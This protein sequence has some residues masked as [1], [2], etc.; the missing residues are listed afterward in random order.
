M[1]LCL[2]KGPIVIECLELLFTAEQ[3]KCHISLCADLYVNS[4][5]VL[6]LLLCY[7]TLPKQMTNF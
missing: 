4:L 5:V 7:L 1:R 6:A 3:N 2:Y